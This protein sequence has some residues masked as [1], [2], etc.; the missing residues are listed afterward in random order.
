MRTPCIAA[1][2]KMYKTIKE[3]EDYIKNFLPA[4]ASVKDVEIIIAT[5]FTAL[6]T[7][8]SLLKGSNVQLSAENV[9]YEKE[10][11]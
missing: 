9:Y 1:N 8:A 5:P 7:A 10:G 3:T 11:A 6:S 4:V 2:W